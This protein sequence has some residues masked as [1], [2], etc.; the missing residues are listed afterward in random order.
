MDKSNSDDEIRNVELLRNS[1]THLKE[2]N[3]KLAA[4][5][6]A[7]KE[8]KEKALLAAQKNISA[9]TVNLETTDKADEPQSTNQ[10]SLRSKDQLPADTSLTQSVKSEKLAIPNKDSQGLKSGSTI[11]KDEFKGLT[12]K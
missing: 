7:V 9:E 1:I 6:K 4:I 10:P 11:S 2:S 5:A 3:T 8:R 12:T